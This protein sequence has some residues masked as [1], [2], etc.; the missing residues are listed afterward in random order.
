ML[1][2]SITGMRPVQMAMI[3]ALIGVTF[4]KWTYNRV[5]GPDVYCC[6]SNMRFFDASVCDNSCTTVVYLRW[7]KGEVKVLKM[8]VKVLIRRRRRRVKAKSTREIIDYLRTKEKEG[9]ERVEAASN[10]IKL[11]I[12]ILDGALEV[13]LLFFSEF[14]SCS[15]VRDLILSMLRI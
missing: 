12:D 15:F 1:S 13:G 5:I 6:Y 11:L 14:G 9:M 8:L 7:P 10:T 3:S 4:M 2:I